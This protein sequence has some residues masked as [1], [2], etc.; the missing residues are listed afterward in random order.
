MVGTKKD[1]SRVLLDEGWGHYI[2]CKEAREVAQAE[3]SAARWCNGGGF[4]AT[5]S[6][7]KIRCLLYVSGLEVEK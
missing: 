4:G 5:R 7:F 2:N 1:D 3:S 6:E